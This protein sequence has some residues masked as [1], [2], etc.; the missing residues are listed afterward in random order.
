MGIRSGAFS[1][2]SALTRL[3]I[4]SKV[5]DIED[6]WARRT[7]ALESIYV[8][9]GNGN[10][11]AQS[12]TLYTK[13]IGGQTGEAQNAL[14]DFAN[15]VLDLPLSTSADQTA[16]NFSGPVTYQGVTFTATDGSTPTRMWDSGKALTFRIYKGGTLTFAVPQGAS[17]IKVT[18]TTS[19]KNCIDQAN[20]GTISGDVWT[21][22]TQSV[23]FTNNTNGN[24]FISSISVEVHGLGEASPW[25]L[26]KAPAALYGTFFNVPEEVA[27]IAPYALEAAGYTAVTL[28]ESLTRLGRNAL[29]MSTLTRIVANGTTPATLITDESST[30]ESPF[31]QVDKQACELLVPQQ[32]ISAYQT[33]PYWEEFY[34]T[35]EIATAIAPVWT[36]PSTRIFWYDLQGRLVRNPGRGVYILNGQKVVR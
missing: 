9:E 16:G 8:A 22:E 29:S 13:H 25:Q 2:C 30:L 24:T 5:A 34:N 1:D 17:I 18:F 19:N 10:Y 36:Q 14:F 35:S 12:G 23:T 26:L 32:S 3:T 7:P 33:A 27:I 6:G 11:E 15:N 28:P 31:T 4:G 20:T 21:G